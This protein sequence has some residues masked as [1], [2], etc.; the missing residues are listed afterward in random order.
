MNFPDEK[1]KLSYIIPDGQ[2]IFDA[3]FAGNTEAMRALGFMYYKG[4][5]LKRDCNKALQWFVKAANLGSKNAKVETERL[6]R[7]INQQ[8]NERD[9]A[10]L[11][12]LYN[13]RR[14][15][16]VGGTN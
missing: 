6:K 15:M 5:G 11:Q 14:R 3:A 12:A 7:L 13:L 1:S 10:I 8:G 4:K 16:A 2:R 9:L